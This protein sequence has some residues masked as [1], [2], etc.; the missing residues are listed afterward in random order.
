MNINSQD[1]VTFLTH[2]PGGGSEEK[3]YKYEYD[4]AGRLQ[5]VGYL[6]E[7]DTP[8]YYKNFTSYDYNANS[9]V[10]IQSYID[11]AIVNNFNYDNRNRVNTQFDDEGIFSIYKQLF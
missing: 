5:K 7:F 10:E 9:Q 11:R 2:M 8:G 1:Q 4:F 6:Y 3:K